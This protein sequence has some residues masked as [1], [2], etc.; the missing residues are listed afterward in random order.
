MNKTIP[1]IVN[2]QKV[3]FDPA[4]HLSVREGAAPGVVGVGAGVQEYLTLHYSNKLSVT[5]PLN[6]LKDL[7]LHSL[8]I[9]AELESARLVQCWRKGAEM[10]AANGEQ[11]D[12]PYPATSVEGLSWQQGVN[13]YLALSERSAECL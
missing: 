7:L 10:A 9:G 12:N 8:T 13:W 2:Q 3:L 6:A 5:I 1:G 11:P 4:L